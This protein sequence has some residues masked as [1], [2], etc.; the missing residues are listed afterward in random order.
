V[1]QPDRIIVAITGASGAIYSLR[2]IKAALEAGTDVELVISDYG[3]RLLIEESELNLK[4][5]SIESW[6][7][8]NWGEAERPGQLRHHAVYDMGSSLASGTQ[9]WIGM[10]VV[11]CSMKTLSGI[12]HGTASNLIE[13]AADVTLKEGRRLAIVPRETPFNLIHLENLS[14]AA[15]AGA[16][17]VPAMPAFYQKP[18]TFE[19]L[20][21]FIAG[22]VLSVLGVR[23]SLVQPWQG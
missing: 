1:S 8:R 23:N 3:R 16:H 20:A 14:R 18:Q 9:E 17:I 13:R 15:R 11:P 21:D 22:R 12:A 4:T 6:L 2:L 10:A 5:E 19:D 7:D